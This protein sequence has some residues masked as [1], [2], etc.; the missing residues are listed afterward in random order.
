MIIF[1]AIDLFA[2]HTDHSIATSQ[3]SARERK[4]WTVTSRRSSSIR[5]LYTLHSNESDQ[6]DSTHVIAAQLQVPRQSFP[7]HL[8]TW[9]WRKPN[10]VLHFV[11][12]TSYS[13]WYDRHGVC[14]V[15][16]I[17]RGRG[18]DGLVMWVVSW[19]WSWRRR[20]EYLRSGYYKL[21]V[22]IHSYLRLSRRW[23][24]SS[25]WLCMWLCFLLLLDSK[26]DILCWLVD[27]FRHLTCCSCISLF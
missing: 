17:A 9:H 18:Y 5:D 4:P 6:V 20:W 7:A 1:R 26:I 14:G 15:L 10:L 2:C 21:V 25:S 24:A 13:C 19:C 8:S 22:V 11:C 12:T 23:A 27:V 3:S 16:G